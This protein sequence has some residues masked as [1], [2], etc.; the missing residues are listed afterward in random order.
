MLYRVCDDLFVNYD[1]LTTVE[2]DTECVGDEHVETV[3]WSSK[4]GEERKAHDSDYVQGFKKLCNHMADFQ[5]ACNVLQQSELQ[6]GS[7]RNGEML[8]QIQQT[9]VFKAEPA[10]TPNCGGEDCPN[11]HTQDQA[12]GVMCEAV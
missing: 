6:I 5:E 2:F 12:D 11:D 4:N 9:R 7:Y 8:S 1:E 3:Y 10:G